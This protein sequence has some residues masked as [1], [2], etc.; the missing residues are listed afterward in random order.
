MYLVKKALQ[1][2]VE[3][4]AP[5]DCVGIVSYDED[6]STEIPLTILNEEGKVSMASFNFYFVI[7]IE[8]PCFFVQARVMKA[9]DNIRTGL[10]TNISGG[11]FSSLGLLQSLP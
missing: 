8:W 1:F 5:S 3:Q 10:W 4:L 2:L 6:V 9:V 7:L 11:L